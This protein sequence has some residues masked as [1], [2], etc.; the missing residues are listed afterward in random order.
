MYHDIFF[1]AEEWFRF[2]L[3]VMPLPWFVFFG[4]A[5]EEFVSF[6]PASLVVGLAGTAALLEGRSLFYLLYLAIL[7]NIGRLFA[8]YFYYWVG[9]KLEDLLLPRLRR[10]FGI[11][12]EQVENIGKRFTGRHFQDGGAL[13][14][15]RL[16]PFFPVT[17]TSIACGM[18]KMDLR[19]YL[20]ASF[21]G[22]FLKDLLYLVLGYVGIA[23]LGYLWQ[24]L[25]P[26]KSYVD[27]L[28]AVALV[29]FLASLYFFRGAGIRFV[30]RFEI[31]RRVLRAL[32][33]KTS[34]HSSLLQ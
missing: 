34:R 20:A 33:S 27:I 8:T 12:H 18:I 11:R 31:G 2:F 32:R 16:T 17:L 29:V 14:L 7:G 15:M 13:F 1:Q 10:S 23:S 4:S 5:L 3:S 6:V 22:N 30:K 25:Q 24:D 21:A 19:V 28:T 26:Y 9:D